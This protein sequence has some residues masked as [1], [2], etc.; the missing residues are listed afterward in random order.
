MNYNNDFLL[1]IQLAYFVLGILTATFI[2]SV[3]CGIWL[4]LSKGAAK[5]YVKDAMKYM[6][7]VLACFIVPVIP[8]VLYPMI[9]EWG[10]MPGPYMVKSMTD[11]LKIVLCIWLVSVVFMVLRRLYNYV[12]VCGICKYNIPVEDETVLR[13]FEIWKSALG[14][15]CKINVSLNANVS[16][17][18]ILYHWGYQ[19]LLPAYDM[20]EQEINMAVL[21][22]LVHLKH[23]DVWTKDACFA[24]NV[25]H[26]FNPITRHIKEHVVRW[27]EVLCDLTTCEIGRDTFTKQDYY[28]GIINLMENA[29]IE[30]R[31]EAI[32]SLSESKSLLEFRVDKFEE[33][34]KPKQ[35]KLKVVLYVVFAFMVLVTSLG[36]YVT[37]S[38]TNAWYEASLK[39]NEREEMMASKEQQIITYEELFENI[40]EK[41]VEYYDFEK[42]LDAKRQLSTEDIW[43]IHIEKEGVRRL[44]AHIFTNA[45]AYMLG[46]VDEKGNVIYIDT[47]ENWV[48]DFESKGNVKALF[49]KNN[50][51]GNVEFD[52]AIE[53]K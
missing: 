6:R 31:N 53:V 36:M 32:F 15:R 46:Y 39:G 7:L 35:K 12:L 28:Y 16:S 2:G 9:K 23:K 52:V 44:T 50:S 43:Y 47:Q 5:F 33:A 48:Q 37:T 3:S 38:A 19:I 22:E 1:G 29:E 10:I 24:V 45:T 27:A 49:I 13:Q 41:Y 20:T 11:I 4:L 26:G 42:S 21:H 8:F 18:S 25:I 30:M 51:M 34:G 40:D 17:P 14:I